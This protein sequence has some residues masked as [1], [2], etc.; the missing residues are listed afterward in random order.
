MC[1]G[2][3]RV[4]IHHWA[5]AHYQR[6]KHKNVDLMPIVVFKDVLHMK[7]PAGNH[8]DVLTAAP[9]QHQQQQAGL[10]HITAMQQVT[11]A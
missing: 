11:D 8:P 1:F 5:A 4:V 3:K 10:G 6:K 2:R 7:C 9:Q